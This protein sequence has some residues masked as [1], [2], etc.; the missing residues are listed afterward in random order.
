M[1]LTFCAVTPDRWPDL[2]ALFS[3]SAE[4][5]EG[6]PA[7]CWC[8]EWRRPRADWE[9]GQGEGNRQAMQA[10]IESGEVPGILAY[11][12]DEPV[13]WCSIAPRPQTTTLKERGAFRDFENPA[14]WTVLCFYISDALRSR[15][16]TVELLRAAVE[17]ARAGGAKLV[18]GYPVDQKTMPD[19]AM[20]RFMGFVSAFR[21]AGFVEVARLP[22]GRPVMRYSVDA[23]P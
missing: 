10:L 20:S 3:R 15:G 16:V 9:A 1:T 21:Q 4:E 2:E 23:T 5:G 11:E 19:F 22:G 18:E 14:I 13:A 17:R 6:N 8:M 12:D 7:S